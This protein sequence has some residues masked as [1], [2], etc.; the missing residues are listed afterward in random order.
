MVHDLKKRG[1]KSNTSAR[2]VVEN[3]TPGS[4]WVIGFLSRSDLF[5]KRWLKIAHGSP[6]LCSNFDQ[7]PSEVAY[8]VPNTEQESLWVKP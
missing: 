7:A 4:V 3:L 2:S 6:N 1:R 8:M 5:H